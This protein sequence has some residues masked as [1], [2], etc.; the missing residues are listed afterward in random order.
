MVASLLRSRFS[1]PAL[2]LWLCLLS[3][4]CLVSLPCAAGD[5][6]G[7]ELLL[8]HTNDQH[9]YLAGRD[10]Q[11]NACL[12]SEGCSGGAARLATAMKRLRATHDNVLA[13]DA[14]D[15]FQGT[16]FFTANRWPMEFFSATEALMAA[17][18][19]APLYVLLFYYRVCSRSARRPPGAA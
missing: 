9:A 6:P 5:E 7:L 14:G 8:L 12:R 17:A 19:L 3:A 2:A 1:A 10:A 18:Y 13:L 11:G 16:L 15:Q 4:F